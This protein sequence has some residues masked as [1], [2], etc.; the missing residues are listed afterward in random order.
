MTIACPFKSVDI[1]SIVVNSHFYFFHA[2]IRLVPLI[3]CKWVHAGLFSLTLLTALDATESKQSD[4]IVSENR[5]FEIVGRDARSVAYAAQLS[6]FIAESILDELSDS[7]YI[8]PRTVLVQLNKAGISEGSEA[9]RVEISQLGFVTLSIQW[10]GELD[11]Y[12]TIESLVAGFIQAYG[13]ASYG[14]AYLVRSPAKA[15][16]IQALASTAYAQL[17]PKMA[18]S[19]Y[20]QAARATFDFE[21]F[22]ARLGSAIAPYPI[23]AQSFALYRWI[24]KQPLRAADKQR[25]IRSAL[26]GTSHAESLPEICSIESQTAFKKLWAQFLRV[27]QGKHLG[28]FMDL[29]RSKA[30]LESLAG[31]SEMTLEGKTQ[32]VHL[33]LGNLWSQRKAPDLRRTLEARIQLISM[34]LSRINPLYYN[35]AQSLA[36]TYQTLLDASHEWEVLSFFSEYLEAMDRAQSIHKQIAEALDSP[37]SPQTN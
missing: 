20:V 37:E 24:Q 5:Y 14:D 9:Y 25:I 10:D 16:I 8:N 2:L 23:P 34:A 1:I 4:L 18:R 30:W 12:A 17:R 29:K 3:L 27:E 6:S 13:Y 36:L 11:L 15:W 35:A 31:F 21:L 32:S 26:L 28:Q 7:S 33:S 19:F 22:D